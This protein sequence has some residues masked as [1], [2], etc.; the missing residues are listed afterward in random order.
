MNTIPWRPLRWGEKKQDQ[1]DHE[2]ETVEEI[3]TYTTTSD[4]T[5]VFPV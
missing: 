5:H 3:A 2:R 4:V 1:E